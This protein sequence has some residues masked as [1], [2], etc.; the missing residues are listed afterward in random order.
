M[1]TPIIAPSLLSA[2]FSKLGEEV[3]ALDGALGDWLHWDV[4]DGRFVPN[5]TFGPPVLAALRPLTKTYCDVHLMMEAPAELLGAFA[6]AGADGLTVHQEVC[7]HLD[8]TLER[9][10]QLG[11]KAGVALNPSTS[12]ETIRYVLDRLDLI[13]IM[14]VNPGF[15]G[16]SFLPA[17]L[18]KI[19][20][21][22]DLIGDRPIH[23]QVDGGI[24][25]TTAPQVFK[26]GADVL[27]AGSFVFQGRT[28]KAYGENIRTLRQACEGKER[29]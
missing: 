28:P 21:V 7:P 1:K 19:K 14:T 20:I 3:S 9:I 26:A 25:A 17:M 12:P 11:K 13:L 4:M 29:Q 18:E 8:R 2:D 10:K 16:Q 24:D 22:A 27:V 23:I 6:A 5:L 15:G